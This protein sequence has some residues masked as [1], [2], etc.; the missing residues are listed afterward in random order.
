MS[1]SVVTP[2]KRPRGRPKTIVTDEQKNERKEQL[3][4]YKKKIYENKKDLYKEYNKKYYEEN[5]DAYTEHNNNI[6]KRNYESYKLIK[7]LFEENCIP[8]E[9]V[10]QVQKL[11]NV[12]FHKIPLS[13]N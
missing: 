6:F 13:P 4:E 10:E 3:K 9:Y 11:I 12:K 8:E 7:K 2:E 1:E 5:K